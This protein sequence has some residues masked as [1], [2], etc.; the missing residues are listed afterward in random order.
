[1]A[2]LKQRAENARKALARRKEKGEQT[3]GQVIQTAEVTGTAAALGY[4]RGRVGEVDDSGA[5]T[6]AVAGVPVD[7]AIGAGLHVIAFA[8]SDK[9]AEH[10]HN[11]GDGALAAFLC[12]RLFTVG[13][14]AAS[15][16]STKGMSRRRLVASRGMPSMGAGYPRRPAA[17]AWAPNGMANNWASPVSQHL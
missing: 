16:T 17:N 11:V 10:L 13:E 1:M 12:S 4:A 5:K 15:E 3:I 7:L 2:S 14:E 8:G 6:L 9:Y